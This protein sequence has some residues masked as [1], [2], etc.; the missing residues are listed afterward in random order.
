MFFFSFRFN[1]IYFSHDDTEISSVSSVLE[2]KSLVRCRYSGVSAWII[3][4]YHTLLNL[5]IVSATIRD[6]EEPREYIPRTKNT[7]FLFSLSYTFFS[8]P[9]QFNLVFTTHRRTYIV[10]VWFLSWFCEPAVVSRLAELYSVIKYDILIWQS[11]CTFWTNPV[12]HG[13]FD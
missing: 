7:K 10:R 4:R 3:D 12:T 8:Q 13:P 5:K 6:G 11:S 2:V 9:L 1:L